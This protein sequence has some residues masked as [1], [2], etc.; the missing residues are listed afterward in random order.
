MRGGCVVAGARSYTEEG[1]Q[2]QTNDLE[3]RKEGLHFGADDA[4]HAYECLVDC[5]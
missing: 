2:L 1:D 4:L 3:E 5:L